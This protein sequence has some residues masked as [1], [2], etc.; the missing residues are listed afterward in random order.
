[1]SA[2]PRMAKAGTP[3]ALPVWVSDDAKLTTSSGAPPR[4]MPAPVTLHWSE[5]RGPGPVTF[6]NDRPAAQKSAG[7]APFNGTA[8]TT[9]TFGAPGDYVLHLTVND[10][11]GEGG[12]GFQCCWTTG[13]VK[14]TVTQ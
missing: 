3:L 12:Q 1:M 5:F 4:N 7:S 9:A 14:V 11:S 13:H 2:P 8:T 10:Y 6:S